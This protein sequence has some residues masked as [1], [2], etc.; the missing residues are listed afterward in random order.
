MKSAR[1]MLRL[2]LILF[3]LFIFRSLVTDGFEIA[4]NGKKRESPP[5]QKLLDGEQEAKVIALRLGEPPKGFANWS[6]RL[7][8][9]QVV[10]LA[11]VDSVS[12][13]TLRKTLKKTG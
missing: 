12:H 3:K 11:I 13:E 1:R 10:E 7:L 8:A 4:L 5:R 6:L 9:K 2:C